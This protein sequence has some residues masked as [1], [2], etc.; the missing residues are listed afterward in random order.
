MLSADS[1]SSALEQLHELGCTDGLP[2]VI[3]TE[4]RVERMILASGLETDMEIASE[5]DVFLSAYGH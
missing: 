4:E 1:E 2:V 5:C 3:P